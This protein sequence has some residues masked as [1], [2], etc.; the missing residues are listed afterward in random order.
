M[1]TINADGCPIHVEVEGP[2]N[3]PVL[4]LSNSL[5]TTLAMWEPQVAAFTQHFRLVRFDRRGHGKSGLPPGPYSMERLGRDVLAILDGLG[6]EKVN[7][8]GLSMGGMEGMWLGANA[9]ERFERMVLSNTN[10]YYPDKSFWNDR[11][12]ALRAAGAIAPMA[13]RLVSFWLSQEFRDREPATAARLTEMLA[14][15]P[16]EGY[17][18]CGQAVRDMDH[19]EILARIKPPTLVI[20]GLRDQATPPSA[21]EFIQSKIPGAKL[22]AVHGAHLANIEQAQAYTDTVL[23]FLRQ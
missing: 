18:A 8:C 17:I 1:P 21:G 3:A 7:W 5:G 12:A 2:D 6:L 16:L 22:A 9:P 19:R 13:E 11:I 20:I 4:M 23:N 10:Y 14:A 15:T